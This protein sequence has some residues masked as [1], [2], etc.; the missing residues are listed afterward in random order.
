MQSVLS[1]ELDRYTPQFLKK[2]KRSPGP[3]PAILFHLL[4]YQA[5][6]YSPNP[7]KVVLDI[8]VITYFI[9]AAEMETAMETGSERYFNT[10]W[11]MIR[12]KNS[13]TIDLHTTYIDMAGEIVAV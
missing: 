10:Y 3:F 9:T 6:P 1:S 7:L 13:R 12:N 5:G 2:F 11:Y 4:V 8:L